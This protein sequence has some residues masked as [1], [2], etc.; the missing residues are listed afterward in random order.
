MKLDANIFRYMTKEDFRVLTAVEMGMKNHELVPVPLIESISNMRRGG[1]YKVITTLLRHK[2]LA[3]ENK[4]YDGY[5]LTYNGYD[6]LA[7]R[8]L[9]SR[10]TIVGVGRRLGVGK[11]SDVHYAEGPNGEVL[12]L[13]LHRL[14]RISFRSIKKNRDY[15]QHRSSAS[16]MYMARLAAVKEFA[17]LKALSGEGFPVPT[18]VD[19]S[20][21]VVVM[22]FLSSTP[23]YH[24]R[25]CDR[26][27][28]LLERIMRLLVRLGRAGIVHGDFNEFNLMV[29]DDLK[30]TVIDFPQ[31]VAMS[32]PN[33][34][35]YF[36]RD[37]QCVVDYF[38]RRFGYE[39]Q[40]RP[41]F[42]EVVEEIAA[43]GGA[44]L[45]TLQLDGVRAEDDALLVAAHRRPE[46]HVDEDGASESESDDSDAG[47]AT[48]E[49]EE[50]AEPEIDDAEACQRGLRSLL[51]DAAKGDD[52]EVDAETDLPPEAEG[53][54]A[55]K[56]EDGS[57]EAAE[58]GSGSDGEE[59]TVPGHVLLNPNR[60]VR[61]TQSAKEARKNL[62]KQQKQKPAKANTQKGRDR[63][64]AQQECKTAKYDY[65]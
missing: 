62:Q 16:W 61:R 34:R 64:L 7:L 53:A 65:C 50:G 30:V 20:R 3:H 58:D 38:R 21:H 40:T 29:D 12:A 10:G 32:H 42:E 63:R 25:S 9:V 15:L 41:S 6:F 4:K 2:L 46:G 43:D 8:A 24:I 39:V 27:A 22:G 11:E 19:Q 33:A 17:Y 37:A 49:G 52:A 55:V 1:A 57:A 26:P 13:K 51:N 36:E 47:S 35:E 59:E 60:R 56:G 5:R 28:V 45:Q 48:S 44:V 31:I 18:P 14:G 54:E 23:L